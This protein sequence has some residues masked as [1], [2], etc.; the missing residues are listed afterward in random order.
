MVPANVHISSFISIVISALDLTIEGNLKA[1]W[2]KSTNKP[3][4]EHVAQFA[5]YD[6][7]QQLK[8]YSGNTF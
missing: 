4:S 6:K 5:F 7:G 3:F 1:D 2:L 8:S